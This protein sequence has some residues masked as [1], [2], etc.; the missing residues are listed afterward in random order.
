MSTF[1]EARLAAVAQDLLAGLLGRPSDLLAF[2]D[3]KEQLKLRHI[4][5]RGVQEVPLDAIAGTLGR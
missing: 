1:D 4:V 5:D 3:V 2:D